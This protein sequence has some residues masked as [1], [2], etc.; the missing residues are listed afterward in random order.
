MWKKGVGH[1]VIE[2]S[3]LR[4]AAEWMIG[5][6]YE[7]CYYPDGLLA[8]RHQATVGVRMDRSGLVFGARLGYGARSQAHDAWNYRL[9][10]L[11]GE[12][13]TGYGWDIASADSRTV[14]A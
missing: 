14:G 9:H 4:P 13:R 3:T 7:A 8:P 5:A 2:A 6:G 12:V 11:T 1:S 10:A